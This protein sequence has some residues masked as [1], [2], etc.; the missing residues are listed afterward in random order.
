MNARASGAW[1]VL[2][3]A[4]ALVAVAILDLHGGQLTSAVIEAGLGSTLYFCGAIAYLARPASRSAWLLL[5]TATLMAISRALGAGL[6]LWSVADPS[7]RHSLGAVLALNAAGWALASAGLALLVTFPDGH[8]HRPYERRLLIAVPLAFLPLQAAQ[9]LGAAVL[10][11]NQFGWVQFAARS[12]LHVAAAEPPGMLAVGLMQA[13]L[14][15]VVPGLMLL[16]LRYRRFGPEQRRQIKWPL[17]AAALSALSL[18]EMFFGPGPPTIPFWLADTQFVATWALLPVGLAVGIVAYRTLDIEDVIRRSVVYG[19]LWALIAG[20]YVLAL[21]VL[22]I[23]A[24]QRVPLALAILLTIAATL[25]IQPA[26]RRLERIADRLVYGPRASG[27][28]LLRQLGLRLGTT[29]AAEDVADSVAAAVQSGL[30]TTWVQV[31][32]DD[33]APRVVGSAGSRLQLSTAAEISAPLV[34][35]GQEIG[36]LECGPR[37]EGGYAAGDQELLSTLGRQAALAI[38]NSQLSSEL[39]RRLQDLAASRARLVHAEETGR[40]RLERDLHDGV[41]QQLV[42]LIARLALARNQFRRDPELAE[43]TLHEGQI[44][45]ERALETVQELA[46]GIHPSVL[47]DRGLLEA[48]EE[49]AMRMPIPVAV[50]PDG[51]DGADRLAPELE[52]AAYFF[53][54]EALANVLKHA[55]ASRAVIRFGAQGG[56]LRVEVEDDGCG[57]DAS[58]APLSGLRGLEDRI[59]A[60]RGSVEMRSSRGS[61]AVL[62]ARLPIGERDGD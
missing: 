2:P 59:E 55:Q 46:R 49:R 43:R 3:G 18:A 32:V 40:R 44:D 31:V 16:I 13:G 34:H 58:T 33:P 41:Q 10:R 57:F 14:L 5:V 28:D 47:T 38:R 27:Y 22:G 30:G 15:V 48:V 52:G 20:V 62:R 39:E 50:Q 45:A 11:A 6:S 1:W 37:L 21:A 26:R 23:A 53:V 29:L 36:R 60:L 7:I 8:A 4:A 12:P 25:L 24:G 9:L 51:L 42:G 35:A 19:A 54:S 61:G 17:Y 56:E